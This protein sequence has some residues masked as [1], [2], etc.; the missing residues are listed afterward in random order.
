MPNSL[1]DGNHLVVLRTRLSLFSHLAIKVMM[2]PPW[3]RNSLWWKNTLWGNGW[4]KVFGWCFQFPSSPPF[5]F[6]RTHRVLKLLQYSILFQYD[7]FHL[8]SHLVSIHFLFPCLTLS[9]LT[10][11]A[12][13]QDW[14]SC[15]GVLL[16]ETASQM[17]VRWSGWW[18]QRDWGHWGYKG[19]W[20][21]Q[22]E[23]APW[24]SHQETGLA[25]H[26][27]GKRRHTYS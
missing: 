15:R 4:V 7:Y 1:T 12:C 20:S 14:F 27:I 22:C 23:S 5:F 16:S 13:R 19:T 11:A 3:T 21:P 24:L 17:R 9:H 2:P 25:A 18:H 10:Y 6:N 8:H 26:V